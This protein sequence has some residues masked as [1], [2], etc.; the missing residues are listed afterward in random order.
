MAT[1][2]NA[3]TVNLFIVEHQG[4]EYHVMVKPDGT[5]AVWT[6]QTGWQMFAPDSDISKACI[7]AVEARNA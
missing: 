1:I 3:V 6:Q 4:T 7:A 2:K 5:Y